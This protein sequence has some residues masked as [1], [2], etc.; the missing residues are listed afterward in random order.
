MFCLAEFFGSPA[1]FIFVVAHLVR[2]APPEPAARARF[3]LD[4][5]LATVVPCGSFVWHA[6]DAAELPSHCGIG[7]CIAAQLTD[8]LLYLGPLEQKW[9]FPRQDFRGSAR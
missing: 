6:S 2:H 5:F 9:K 7:A 4:V 8:G 3:L 1:H